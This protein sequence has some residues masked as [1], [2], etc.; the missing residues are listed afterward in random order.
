MAVSPKDAASEF[1]KA[2]RAHRATLDR[3]LDRRALLIQ[4]R[5]FDK[6]QDQLE[7]ALTRRVPPGQKQAVSPLQAQQLLLQ[8]R[9]SQMFISKRL[10]QLLEPVLEEAQ[11]EGIEQTAESTDRLEFF[12]WGKRPAIPFDEESVKR[13]LVEGRSAQIKKTNEAAWLAMGAAMAVQQQRALSVSLALEETPQEAISRMRQAADEEWWRG[14]R[15][16]HTEMAVSYNLAQADAITELAAHGSDW[17]KRW[18]ELVDDTTGQPLDSRVGNDSIALH[19]QI[20]DPGGR[21]V[22]PEDPTVDRSFWNKAW[23]S[24]P[25]RPNDRSITMPVR[26]SWGIPSYRLINGERVPVNR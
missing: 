16:I 21:F 15:I 2:L 9:E 10:S 20:A 13:R 3:L 7:R 11:E 5:Y 4:R 22:M 8:V 17:V 18:C 6:A 12:F 1:Q 19:G 26:L 24:S 25:N 14:K 23:L